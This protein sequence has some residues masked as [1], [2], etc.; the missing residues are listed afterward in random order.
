MTSRTPGSGSLVGE[1]L[2]GR[3]R[4][5]VERVVPRGEEYVVAV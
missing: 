4:G 3:A 2:A 5:G 1:E